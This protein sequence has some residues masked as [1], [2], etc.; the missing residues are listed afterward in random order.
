MLNLITLK[1]IVNIKKGYNSNSVTIN[2]LKDLRNLLN[3]MYNVRAASGAYCSGHTGTSYTGKVSLKE[4]NNALNNLKA[5]SCNSR[6]VSSVTCDCNGR[7]ACSCNGRTYYSCSC[8]GR[9]SGCNCNNYI[10]G[11]S[12][13]CNSNTVGATCS[14]NGRTSGCNCN[15]KITSTV[16]VQ[17]GYSCICNTDYVRRCDT[18]S[19]CR[20]VSNNGKTDYFSGYINTAFYDTIISCTCNTVSQSV[21]VGC[22]T[23]TTSTD[24]TSYIASHIQNDSTSPT[25]CTTQ[26][27][28]SDCTSYTSSSDCTS[29]VGALCPSRTT[30]ACNTVN[31][32]N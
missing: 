12:S 2:S 17:N 24:C 3:D 23:Q 21:N 15:D 11:C 16:Q 30:C 31:E 4:M 20:C 5:C 9:T 19:Y 13:R 25:G 26:T 32:F 27:T 14:C 28:A 6:T 29:Y 7:I 18:V 10:S 22:T 1:S 8:N